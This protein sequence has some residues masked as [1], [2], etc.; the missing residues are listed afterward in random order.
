MITNEIASGVYQYVAGNAGLMALMVIAVIVI[1]LFAIRAGKVVVLMLIIPVISTFMVSTA[2]I[3]I[4]KYTAILM[5]II[6]GFIF[7]G[8]IIAYAFRT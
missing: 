4:P 8:A 3:E 7:G 1:M 6:V 2:M 5:F